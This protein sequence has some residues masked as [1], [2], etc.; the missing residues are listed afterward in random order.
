M[1]PEVLTSVK[2]TSDWEEKLVRVAHGEP[3]AQTFTDGIRTMTAELAQNAHAPES[4]PFPQSHELKISML[5]ERCGIMRMEA[6][7]LSERR[8]YSRKWALL[9]QGEYHAFI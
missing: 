4:N 5:V 3:P 1:L 6:D 8:G 9:I 2:L 7:Y